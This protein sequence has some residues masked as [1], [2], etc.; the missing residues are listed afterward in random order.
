VRRLH[1]LDAL[2]GLA[3]FCVALH[4]ACRIYGQPIPPLLPSTSVDLFFILSGFVMTRTYE[5]RLT[6][7]LSTV[8]FLR[9]RY[10]R[11]FA[12]LA[13]G[14]TIGLVWASAR[15]GPSTDLVAAYVTILGFMPAF[16]MADCFLLNGPAWSL[17]LEISANAAHGLAF[18]RMQNRTLLLLWTGSTVLFCALFFSGHSKWGYSLP[19]ILS[20]APRELSCYLMG[21]L[22]FRHY[23][24]E[25]FGRLPFTAIALFPV[26]LWL[27]TLNP[28]LEVAA[29]LIAAPLIIRASLSLPNTGWAVSIG[30]MSYPLYATHQT[31]LRLMA[32][33]GVSGAA[34]F[35]LAL[36]GAALLAVLLLPSINFNRSARNVCR[37]GGEDTNSVDWVSRTV[38][39]S[40]T[41]TRVANDRLLVPSQA[42]AEHVE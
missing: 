9:I 8:G 30:A 1:G 40:N 12:P 6:S 33:L 35:A 14:S 18:A 26:V 37:H 27:A 19:W 13:V 38:E 16:W 22:L 5:G 4:H 21:I 7:G 41:S 25:P 24:D 20:L 32:S 11:L 31:F 10:K 15:F 36:A 2:R 23:R 3:A 39:Q 42:H 34:A 29:T 17:F 28:V